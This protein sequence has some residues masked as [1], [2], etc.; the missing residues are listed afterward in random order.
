MPP[1]AK[2]GMNGMPRLMLTTWHFRVI[3][4]LIPAATAS[5]LRS[6]ERTTLLTTLQGITG[7][8]GATPISPDGTGVPGTG[9]TSAQS[10]LQVRVPWPVLPS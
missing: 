9:T 2:N 6:G 8:R 10:T 5:R 1:V 4:C 7:R 3:A